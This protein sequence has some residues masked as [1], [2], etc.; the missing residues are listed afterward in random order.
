MINI[1]FSHLPHRNYFPIL[2]INDSKSPICLNQIKTNHLINIQHK[3][4]TILISLELLVLLFL[5]KH[6]FFEI[7]LLFLLIYGLD[8]N[9]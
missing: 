6:L 9:L 8:L 1:Y 5:L 2:F 3:Q 4:P 7:L